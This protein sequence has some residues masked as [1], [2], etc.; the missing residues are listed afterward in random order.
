MLLEVVESRNILI[1]IDQ[2]VVSREIKQKAT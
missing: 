2:V 1:I